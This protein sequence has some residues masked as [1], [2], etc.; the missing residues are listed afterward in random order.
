MEAQF[1]TDSS[2]VWL[3]L[4]KGTKLEKT[5][6]LVNPREEKVNVSIVWV[7]VISCILILVMV[8]FKGVRRKYEKLE[9]SV[10]ALPKK[11]WKNKLELLFKLLE[12]FLWTM[13]HLLSGGHLCEEKQ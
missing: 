1:N 8:C 12:L 13:C 4:P 10:R 7:P 2:A 6:M 11:I 5:E 9:Q 3:E